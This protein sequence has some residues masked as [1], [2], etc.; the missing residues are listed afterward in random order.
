MK[1]APANIEAAKKLIDKY[2]SLTLKDVIGKSPSDITGFGRRLSCLLCQTALRTCEDCI[3]Y[4]TTQKMYGCRYDKHCKT[5]EAILDGQSSPEL[6]LKAFYDRAQHIRKVL[7]DL[8]NAFEPFEVTIKV[9]TKEEA[10][11]LNAVVN[12]YPNWELL[13][14]KLAT[15][16]IEQVKKN[17]KAKDM[18]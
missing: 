4:P 9:T 14:D 1:T 11:A 15:E 12:Y 8:E 7:S 13:G 18:K 16:I 17:I 5:F 6:L 10:Q 3:Y 2:E